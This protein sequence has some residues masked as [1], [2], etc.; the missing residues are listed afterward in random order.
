MAGPLKLEASDLPVTSFVKTTVR[1]PVMICLVTLPAESVKVST[2]S[3]VIGNVRVSS[4]LH[5]PLKVT[6]G[7]DAGV[8]VGPSA[9]AGVASTSA[10][11]TA[12]AATKGLFMD[13]PSSRRL[14]RLD[15]RLLVGTIH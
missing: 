4:K 8:R 6:G 14:D 12:M 1:W 3:V 11:K 9:A 15:A 10:A 7:L 2:A 5:R 13:P